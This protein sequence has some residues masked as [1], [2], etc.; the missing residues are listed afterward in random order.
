MY[1]Y[2]KMINTKYIIGEF[3][4]ADL[5]H[6]ILTAKVCVKYLKEIILRK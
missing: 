6:L 2:L 4:K 3:Y 1:S 5:E